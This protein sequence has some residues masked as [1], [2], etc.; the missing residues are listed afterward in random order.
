MNSHTIYA[1]PKRSAIAV[2]HA[3]RRPLPH[4]IAIVKRFNDKG[5]LVDEQLGMIPVVEFMAMMASAIQE[6]QARADMEAR[7]TRHIVKIPGSIDTPKMRAALD[8]AFRFRP[9]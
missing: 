7:Y 9:S 3:M 4:V 6:Q 5:R 1:L 2:A 8:N